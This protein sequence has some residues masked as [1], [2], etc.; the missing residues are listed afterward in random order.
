M[1]F[2]WKGYYKNLQRCKKGNQHRK[3][4]FAVSLAKKDRTLLIKLFYQI[5]C[6][7]STALREY[8]RLNRLR[9]APMSRQDLKNTIQKFE[10]T[11]DLGVMRGRERK[12]I[13][14]E[15]VKDE[16]FAVVELVRFP[17]FYVKR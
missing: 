1:V 9:K 10:E 3:P 2:I 17:I 13:L 8:R 11:R 7:L 4:L 15:A 5:S 12:R 6:N 14:N 16:I